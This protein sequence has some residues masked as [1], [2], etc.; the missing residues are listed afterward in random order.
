MMMLLTMMLTMMM[1]TAPR[2]RNATGPALSLPLNY[3]LHRRGASPPVL[4]LILVIIST[5]SLKIINTIHQPVLK[6]RGRYN[7]LKLEVRFTGLSLLGIPNKQGVLG[8]QAVLVNRYLM[9]R[10]TNVWCWNVFHRNT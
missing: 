8:V 3:R 5:F 6:N 1:M 2:A 7:K 9:I 4:L 10:H